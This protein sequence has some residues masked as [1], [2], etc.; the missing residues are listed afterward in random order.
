MFSGVFEAI[1]I[2]MYFGMCIH[3]EDSFPTTIQNGS[4][5][6]TFATSFAASELCLL[7]LSGYVLTLRQ[8]PDCVQT[9]T[10]LS[11]PARTVVW[12][13]TASPASSLQT[14]VTM[15]VLLF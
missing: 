12:P 5:E 15:A 1:V 4:S 10:V 9:S 2:Q 11:G 13:A 7:R 8:P 14:M 3:F 6:T